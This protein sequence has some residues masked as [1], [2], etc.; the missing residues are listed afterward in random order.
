M[1]YSEFKLDDNE[2]RL[3][4]SKITSNDAQ[5]ILEDFEIL[6]K[7][8][9]EYKKKIE[10][11]QAHKIY[12]DNYIS[13]LQNNHLNV[14]NII[15][16]YDIQG[17]NNELNELFINYNNK[18]KNN[19]DK[20]IIQNYTVKILEF[21]NTI[22]IIEKKIIEF[23]TL[24]IYII[25]KITKPQLDNKKLCPICFENEVD[26]CLNPCGHTL[27]NKCVISNRSRYTNEKC[28]SCRGVI[29]DYIKIYFS[30]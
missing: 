6:N 8:L 4:L 5:G 29:H 9:D 1:N 12:F 30:F 19:Y 3:E 20:W 25:N 16:D 2:N 28:Y 27:C 7:N 14:M 10:D 18:M 24:F 21:E 26:I 17:N 22:D 15:N 23:R 11:L 13:N